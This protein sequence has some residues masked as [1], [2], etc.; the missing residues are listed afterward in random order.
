MKKCINCFRCRE[1]WQD[2]EEKGLV[3]Q[4]HDILSYANK[5]RSGVKLRG[6]GVKCPEEIVDQNACESYESRV[7]HNINTWLYRCKN[8][9]KNIIRKYIIVPI[10]G[11]R[12]AV[13]LQYED[14]YGQ[15]VPLC[16]HCGEMPYSYEQCFFCGQKFNA[17]PIP[18]LKSTKT[19]IHGQLIQENDQITF[20]FPSLSANVEQLKNMEGQK[21]TGTV[22]Y[23]GLWKSFIIKGTTSEGNIFF[24]FPLD[25]AQDCLIVE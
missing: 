14:S 10:G 18:L 6:V 4:I 7:Q 17:T 21:A 20:A 23:N 25:A 19:D 8:T 3:P 9:V 15:I 1:D 5:P 24:D 12:K 16:P 2:A 22:C 11:L 13:Y